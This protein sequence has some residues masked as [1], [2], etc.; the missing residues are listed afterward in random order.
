MTPFLALYGRDPPTIL[1]Y[2]EGSASNTQVDQA[3][4]DRDELLCVLKHNLVQAQGRKK[5]QADKHRRELEFEEGAWV[6]VRFQPYRQLSLR[7]RKHDKLGPRLCKGQS[8]Q[9]ITPLPL[10]CTDV[11]PLSEAVNLE[12]KLILSGGGPV[13][14]GTKTMPRGVED[15]LGDGSNNSTA[16]S[17]TTPRITQEHKRK[18][19]T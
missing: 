14:E 4:Q 10:L 3:L 6:Y 12:D 2:L 13:I 19:G 17:K 1:S 16:F 7:L 8:L 11:L 18:E 5:N 9:Q 15:I